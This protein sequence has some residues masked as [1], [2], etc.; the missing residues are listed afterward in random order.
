MDKYIQLRLGSIGKIQNLILVPEWKN[1]YHFVIS[2]PI[3]AKFVY[4]D[5]PPE[6]MQGY[7]LTFVPSGYIYPI[8]SDENYPMKFCQ[9]YNFDY[10]EKL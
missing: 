4:E 7:K 8:E 2:Q 1:I 6:F 9:I 3:T 5:S 10:M